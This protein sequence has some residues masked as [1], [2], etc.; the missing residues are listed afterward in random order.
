MMPANIYIRAH[1]NKW[2]D[3]L[4][5]FLLCCVVAVPKTLFPAYHMKSVIYFS[6]LVLVCVKTVW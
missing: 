1:V 5:R 6:L 4:L 3:V 2:G